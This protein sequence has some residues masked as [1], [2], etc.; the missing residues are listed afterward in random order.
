[1]TAPTLDAYVPDECKA[2]KAKGSIFLD[3][4]EA[5]VVCEAC[6]V[7]QETHCID[8]GREWRN[9][10][11]EGVGTGDD[12]GSGRERAD[13]MNS[14]TEWQAELST[15][16][17]GSGRMSQDLQGA[18]ERLN[19]ASKVTLTSTQR[20]NRRR[21]MWD[22]KVKDLLNL[23]GMPTLAASTRE[24]LEDYCQKKKDAAVCGI[25][26]CKGSFLEDPSRQ[27]PCT[28][29]PGLLGTHVCSKC[30]SSHCE[31]CEDSRTPPLTDALACAAIHFAGHKADK[32]TRG[33][34]CKASFK[35]L[36]HEFSKKLKKQGIN[37]AAVE[38]NIKEISEAVAS[39]K[40][41]TEAAHATEEVFIRY[42]EEL[43]LSVKVGAYAF[44]L[45][46]RAKTLADT[47]R[48]LE[49]KE[50]TRVGVCLYVLYHLLKC[51]KP[52]QF[53]EFIDKAGGEPL[54]DAKALYKAMKENVLPLLRKGQVAQV[55]PKCSKCKHPVQ[56]R[57]KEAFSGETLTCSVEGC[58]EA[59]QSGCN[60]A[61]CQYYLCQK[62][63]KTNETVSKRQQEEFDQA[64]E[65]L[66]K[67][68]QL[69]ILPQKPHKRKAVHVEADD[70]VSL[71]F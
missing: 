7:V 42:A 43:G 62:H 68:I 45:N 2:C 55:K 23:L 71:L 10:S 27:M 51:P 29:C 4:A 64:M 41:E 25:E 52:L 26:G 15:T 70:A 48:Q 49:T 14:I 24:L 46:E 18:Q 34:R 50:T 54:R 22:R 44:V 35:L 31:Q 21:E 32:A 39:L 33:G 13:H 60:K 63:S 36:P 67:P 8:Y 30:G 57:L 11:S 16:I 1:M 38:R 66:P 5:Q 53:E 28:R 65:E 56:K 9:F 20:G 3:P 58:K 69:P 59:A 47:I 17:S 6:G 19:H 40:G 12:Q 61:E 37:K